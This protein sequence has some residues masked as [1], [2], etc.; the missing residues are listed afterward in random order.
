MNIDSASRATSMAQAF[1]D[2]AGQPPRQS[3]SAPAEQQGA[4]P[5]S[6]GHAR[7]ANSTMERSLRS[8]L[9]SRSA[10]APAAGS[11]AAARHTNAAQQVF[12]TVEHLLSDIPHRA[13][14][15]LAARMQ[16]GAPREPKDIDL[17]FRNFGDAEQ[18]ARLLKDFGGRETGQ[19]PQ[20]AYFLETDREH[21]VSITMA[22]MGIARSG[23]RP[24]QLAQIELNNE[25][26]RQGDRDFKHLPETRYGSAQ[27]TLMRRNSLVAG[28]LERFSYTLVE[29][30]PDDK[31]DAAQLQHLLSG[32]NDEEL[33]TLTE[34]IA[35]HFDWQAIRSALPETVEASSSEEEDVSDTSG[36]ESDSGAS[37]T[38]SGARHAFTF[39]S[40]GSVDGS[41]SEEEDVGDTSGSESGSGSS[42]TSSGARHAFAFAPPGSV[43]G[44]S[45]AEEDVSDASGSHSDNESSSASASGESARPLV[46]HHDQ[47]MEGAIGYLGQLVA[48]EQAKRAERG[49]Q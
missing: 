31:Q 15:S 1:L 19:F 40:P 13:G 28:V 23:E 22:A 10:P 37:I 2:T 47:R 48:A 30:T 24:T 44:S 29:R 38:S 20:I 25:N 14:G 46:I 33:A 6:P 41:S 27:P 17:E 21:N 34:D 35:A 11:D 12:P 45:S 3:A 9:A 36:S 8:Q 5:S 26:T 16:Y 18:A 49:A 39:A 4:R 43:D 42:A 32:M 7:G